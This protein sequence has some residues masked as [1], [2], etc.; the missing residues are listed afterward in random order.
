MNLENLMSDQRLWISFWFIIFL[1]I[2]FLF[3]FKKIKVKIYEGEITRTANCCTVTTDDLIPSFSLQKNLSCPHEKENDFLSPFISFFESPK[4]YVE[5]IL[6][7][8]IHGKKVRTNFKIN[9]KNIEDMY[10]GNKIKII[11]LCFFNKK[12]LINK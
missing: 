4:E 1:I 9:R 5:D 6:E 12:I 11:Y 2:F 8:K 10:I 7:V 3:L